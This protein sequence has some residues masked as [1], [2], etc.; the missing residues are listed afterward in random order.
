MP[1]EYARTGRRSMPARP[2]RSSAASTRARRVRRL[3]PRPA[4]S[5]S[6]RLLRPDRYG[7]AAG[8]SIS[9]PMSG[10]TSATCFGTGRPS[11]SIFPL[12]A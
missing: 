3:P 12:V 2:T 4:A 6:A 11:T 8:P 10:N 5:K 1:S 9:A 7:Y